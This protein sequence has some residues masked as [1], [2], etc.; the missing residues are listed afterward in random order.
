MHVKMSDALSL[1]R[2][3]GMQKSRTHYFL[4]T[5]G[6]ALIDTLFSSS[7]RIV[8]QH[9]LFLCYWSRLIKVI[10]TTS[11][12]TQVL[13]NHEDHSTKHLSCVLFH[14]DWVM[15]LRWIWKSAASGYHAAPQLCLNRWSTN[16]SSQTQ[17]FML[18][19]GIS[20]TGCGPWTCHLPPIGTTM[21]IQFCV[22]AG[23]CSRSTQRSHPVIRV[24]VRIS[25]ASAD[26]T[27]RWQFLGQQSGVERSSAVIVTSHLQFDLFFVTQMECRSRTPANSEPCLPWKRLAWKG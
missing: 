4:D 23:R 26:E 15:P 7:F 19:L 18:S 17:F 13:H 27:A 12:P 22:F 25:L 6:C 8:H 11:S 2:V 20:P 16:V 14:T 3:P 10:P 5:R 1:Q 24:V 21:S 9:W